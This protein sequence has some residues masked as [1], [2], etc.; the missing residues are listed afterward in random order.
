[1]SDE[2][3][4]ERAPDMTGGISAESGIWRRKSGKLN[5]PTYLSSSSRHFSMILP[6]GNSTGAMI[7]SDHVLRESGSKVSR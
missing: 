1:M 2:S 6:T 3:S 4:N 7:P 5:L